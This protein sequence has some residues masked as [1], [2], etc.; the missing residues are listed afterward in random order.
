MGLFDTAQRGIR[1][2]FLYMTMIVVPVAHDLRA[3]VE[4]FIRQVYE[5]HHQATITQF[6]PLLLAMLDS[7]GK[8]QCASGLRFAEGGFFSECYLDTPIELLLEDRGGRPVSR[9]DIFEVT[10]LASS[11]PGA[12]LQFLRRIVMYGEFAGFS[13]AF[14][15]ATDR[16]RLLLNRIELPL[17]QLG[18]APRWRVEGPASWGTYYSNDPHVCAVD[19][20]AAAL[21][22]SQFQERT[23]HA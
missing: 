7:H 10:S 13:W 22:L 1:R 2:E 12:A 4:A 8:I 15:T 18:P 20:N 9:E 16:L 23:A 3:R 19:R 6:P 11:A 21:F 5:Q 17:V 14:F